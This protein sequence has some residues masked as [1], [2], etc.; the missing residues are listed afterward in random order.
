VHETGQATD[1]L[2]QLKRVRVGC[3]R[4]SSRTLAFRACAVLS[5]AGIVPVRALAADSSP[6]Q[7]ADSA[8]APN[9]TPSGSG[10]GPVLVPPQSPAGLQPP[11]APPDTTP[12]KTLAPRARPQTDYYT[13]RLEPAG[14]P[15]IGGSS[16]IGFQV[17]VVGTLSYFADGIEPYAWNQDLFLSLSFNR[18]PGGNIEI[19][20]Q[21]YQWNVDYPRLFGKKIRLN[22]QIAFTRTVN[23]GYF[24]LGNES[25][26]APAPPGTPNPSRYHQYVANV[27]YARTF[28]RF[29]F[30]R[31]FALFAGETFRYINPV[32]YAGSLLA[33]EEGQRKPDGSPLLLGTGPMSLLAVMAGVLIDSRDNEIF[34]TSG[35]YHQIG[36][37]FEQ[38]LP[39]DTNVQY[40]E[41][42]AILSGFVPVGGPLVLASRLVAD[43]Q[44]LQVP[45]FDLSVAGPFQLKDLPGGSSGIR[46]VPIGRFLGPIK[47]VGNV[48]LRA[49]LLHA[50]IAKQKFH[51]GGDLLFVVGRVWSDYT[52]HSPLDG[53]GIALHW[54]AGGGIY[55]LWGQ[56]AIFR[57]EAAYSPDTASA[58]GLP[59][60]L[61]V[62]DGTMF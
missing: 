52:F 16:D 60:G 40:T 26:G 35:V 17:G 61:Y 44:F 29:D 5:V 47:G 38:G 21:S 46:G 37:R 32:T 13:R 45:F 14:F 1:R 41:A 4:C 15:L 59:V 22:P 49:L 42:G 18:G 53:S 28:A 3:Y 62:E 43:F 50:T 27:M 36:V 12:S 39:L 11:R 57:I 54:G 9:P 19:A 51:L 24:G 31:P 6:P 55:L 20:Q 58:G 7:P 25:S 56:A 30:D 34:T 48:E 8:P 10:P 2:L 23:E 33:T